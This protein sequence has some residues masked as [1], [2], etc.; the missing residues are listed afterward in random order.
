MC[1]EIA[2]WMKMPY[3]LI[4][5]FICRLAPEPEFQSFL[6]IVV[7]VVSIFPPLNVEIPTRLMDTWDDSDP[8]RSGVFSFPV[9]ERVTFL[10][11]ESDFDDSFAE[12][13]A[14]LLYA[15]IDRFRI[16]WRAVPHPHYWS[17]G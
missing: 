17:E 16:D 5:G 1:V 4:G 2:W 14:H 7:F 13:S 12:L 6:P 3:R 8:C 9:F 11:P 15:L 10:I